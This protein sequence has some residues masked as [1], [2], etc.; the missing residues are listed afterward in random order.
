MLGI[1]SLAYF[2]YVLDCAAGLPLSVKS[3]ELLGA[4]GECS[5]TCGFSMIYE[6]QAQRTRPNVDADKRGG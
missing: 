6:N 5:L 3:F 4:L 2:H 1:V